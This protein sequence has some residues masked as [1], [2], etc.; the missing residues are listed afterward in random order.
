MAVTSIFLSILLSNQRYEFINRRYQWMEIFTST[1]TIVG[2][3][4][5]YILSLFFIL[6]L[7]F[8]FCFRL[9]IKGWDIIWIQFEFDRYLF[10]LNLYPRSVI[11]EVTVENV[12][13]PR[14]DTPCKFSSL[15]FTSPTRKSFN[16]FYISS[17]KY[18]NKFRMLSFTINSGLFQVQ[19]RLLNR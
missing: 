16:Y 14:P 2:N 8:L 10:F 6:Y 4:L 5:T 7:F 18:Y 17:L 1:E 11:M 3:V 13:C 9:L 15:H 12:K 19:G